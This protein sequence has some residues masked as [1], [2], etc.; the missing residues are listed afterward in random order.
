MKNTPSTNELIRRLTARLSGESR[1]VEG[2]LGPLTSLPAPGA[3][4]GSLAG[5][6]FIAGVAGAISL[7]DSPYPRPGS[8]PA[9][10]RRYFQENPGAA[11]ISVG[12]QLISAASPAPLTASGR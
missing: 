2:E 10:I 9:D 8:E 1:K 6:S 12:G 4:S 7:A 5:V 11:C 3:L